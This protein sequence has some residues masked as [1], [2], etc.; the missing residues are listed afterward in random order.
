MNEERIKEV[1]SDEEFMKEF[2]SKETPEEA[3]E[4]LAEKDIDVSV[5][6]LCKLMDMLAAKSENP[7]EEMELDDEELEDV[8]GG[9][10][11]FLVG[12]FAFLVASAVGCTYLNQWAETGR[13]P[14]W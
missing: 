1:F 5:D 8:A 3:Q 2:L 4:L 13:K 10:L 14:R 7:D 12:V 6:D 11:A 9:S